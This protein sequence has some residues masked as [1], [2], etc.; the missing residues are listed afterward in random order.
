LPSLPPSPFPPPPAPL[1]AA[2][3]PE[4]TNSIPNGAPK[5]TDSSTAAAA[6]ALPAQIG[7][8]TLRT[9]AAKGD[10]A[11]AFEIGVRYADGRGVPQNLSAAAE[12]F[13]R[14]A[15]QGLAPAQFRLGGLYEKGMGVAKNPDTARRLYVAAAEAGNAKAMHN[16]AVLYAE[17]IDGKP[18]YQTAAKWFA[19]A[20]DHGVIDSQFNL[21]ILYARGIGVPLNLTEAYKW[22]A[23]ATRDGDKESA[24]KRDDVAARL[25]QQSLAAARLAVQNW[26]AKPQPD[27]AV[28][29]K[30]P[31]GGWDDAVPAPVPG[32]RQASTPKLG[33]NLLPARPGRAVQ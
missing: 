13:G 24:R 12:W 25:D 18:D 16:L 1:A 31:A 30:T 4:T 6:D 27:A 17:G 22:F 8:K 23:L 14:A 7:S 29:V 3:D 26:T 33:F 9:A 28:Q 20:A 21:G 5:R 11:A 19:S 15:D 2:P 32:K 10:P